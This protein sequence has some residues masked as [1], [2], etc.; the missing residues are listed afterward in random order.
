MLIRHGFDME[1]PEHTQ[2]SHEMEKRENVGHGY[3]LST[4]RDHRP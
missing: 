4:T 3:A 2:K 1:I